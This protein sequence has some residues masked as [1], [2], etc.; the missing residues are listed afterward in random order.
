MKIQ[1]MQNDNKT[2]DSYISPFEDGRWDGWTN[3]DRF[4]WLRSVA[5]KLNEN[6]ELIEKWFKPDAAKMKRLEDAV[7]AFEAVCQQE[8]D[9]MDKKL[10]YMEAVRDMAMDEF[11]QSGAFE[12]LAARGFSLPTMLPPL[13]DKKKGN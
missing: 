6:K 3:L 7:K 11:L 4:N 8:I 1:V 2:A 13:P 10:A 5:N 9:I 12:R